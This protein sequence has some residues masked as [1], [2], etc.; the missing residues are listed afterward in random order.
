TTAVGLA[1]LGRRGTGFGAVLADFDL[2]GALDLAFVNGRIKRASDSVAD[3]APRKLSGLLP[4]LDPFWAPY[5][6]RNQLFINDDTGHFREISEA[7]PVFCGHAAVG[8]GLAC[9][10]VDNDG[11]LDLL[12]I[13]AGAPAQLLRNVAP[14]RGHWLLVRAID[15]RLGGRDAYGAE[16]TV[17]AGTRRWWRL[18]QPGYSFLV[19]N[20][21]RVHFGLGQIS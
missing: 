13:N 17:R 2:D 4:G 6:Q 19:S 14:K 12:I 9:G 5:A 20:D 16:I 7:N 18:V 3:A 21:P 1:N 8:R 15:P 10:D 11:A